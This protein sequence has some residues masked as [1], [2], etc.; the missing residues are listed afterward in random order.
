MR[1][2]FMKVASKRRIVFETVRIHVTYM[3]IG[4]FATGLNDDDDDNEW[5]DLVR[6]KSFVHTP[7]YLTK[8]YIDLTKNIMRFLLAPGRISGKNHAKGEEEVEEEDEDEEEAEAKDED[9]EEEEEKER[10]EM[11]RDETREKLLGAMTARKL[12][13]LQKFAPGAFLARSSFEPSTTFVG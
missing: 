2:K 11:R 10:E 13:Y 3:K 8:F 7:E 9:E 4:H 12:D 5:F 1:P 6:E